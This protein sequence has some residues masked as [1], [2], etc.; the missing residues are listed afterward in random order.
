M[1]ADRTE[2]KSSIAFTVRLPSGDILRQCFPRDALVAD[3]LACALRHNEQLAPQLLS[4]TVPP[5]AKVA[6]ASEFRLCFFVRAHNG[7]GGG[8]GDGSSVNDHAGAAGSLFAEQVLFADVRRRLS[9]LPVLLHAASSTATVCGALLCRARFGT[10]WDCASVTRCIDGA[11]R[12]LV[13]TRETVAFIAAT[14]AM[15][16]CASSLSLRRQQRAT[17]SDMCPSDTV[18]AGRNDIRA[19]PHG[20]VRN[21]SMP[22]LG[23]VRSV[24]G[25]DSGVGGGGSHGIGDTDGGGGHGRRQWLRRLTQCWQ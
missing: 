18:D 20:A 8:D 16:R 19:P 22:V 5:M 13:D 21:I 7:S 17:S 4:T 6:S 25:I 1:K 2:Y 11:S 9:D 24:A 15:L 3:V 23:V 10:E 14:G 12:W